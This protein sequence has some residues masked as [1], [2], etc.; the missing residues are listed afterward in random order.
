MPDASFFSSLRPL[1]TSVCDDALLID[2][3]PCY[4]SLLHLEKPFYLLNTCFTLD[5]STSMFSIFF[6]D[7]KSI[8]GTVLCVWGLSSASEPL[9]STR[10]TMSSSGLDEIDLN[11]LRVSFFFECPVET[12]LSHKVV[13]FGESAYFGFATLVVDPS[14]HKTKSWHIEQQS[15]VFSGCN[16][17]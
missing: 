3:C 16:I 4:H 11:S 10:Q 8:G 9:T 2:M 6:S 12:C 5:S 1:A 7:S 14:F 13:H 17:F 15:P